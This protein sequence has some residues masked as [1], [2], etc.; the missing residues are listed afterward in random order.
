MDICVARILDALCNNTQSSMR[1]ALDLQHILRICVTNL[2][3]HPSALQG[4]LAP[5]CAP[6]ICISY[7]LPT[8]DRPAPGCPCIN[9]NSFLRFGCRP[10]NVIFAY[11]RFK[12]QDDEIGKDDLAAWACIRLDRLRAGYRFVHLRD[13]A[14]VESR[15]ALL[16]GIEKNV[17]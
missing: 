1:L 11:D 3:I 12:I 8:N 17:M 6:C 15:G 14:G 10:T 13:A 9:S 7:H 2:F 4:S 16:V 5:L